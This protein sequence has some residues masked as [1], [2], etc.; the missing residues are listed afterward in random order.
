MNGAC[1]QIDNASKYHDGN[2]SCA[3]KYACEPM[4]RILMKELTRLPEKFLNGF[5]VSPPTVFDSVEKVGVSLPKK[6]AFDSR[7]SDHKRNGIAVN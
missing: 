5:Q 7:L 1:Q 3:K 6:V 2:A 4:P